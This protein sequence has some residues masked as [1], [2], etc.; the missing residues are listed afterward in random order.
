MIFEMLR[1]W[2]ATGWIQAFQRIRDWTLAVEHMFSLTLLVKT[3]F[4]PWKRIVAAP[5]RGLDAKI[6]AALDNFV[7]RCI[8]FVI[9]VFVIVAAAVGMIMAFMASTVM[10]VL[11]PLLPVLL[12]ICTVKGITG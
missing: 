5:G 1:W 2:Y 4:A 11:W 12:V 10:A 7:S 8:G 6:H 9:R 3:L